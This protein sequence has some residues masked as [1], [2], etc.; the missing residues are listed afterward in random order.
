[1]THRLPCGCLICIICAKK[2][3]NNFIKNKD[4][5]KKNNNLS[6]S[7]CNCGYNLNEKDQE[8]ILNN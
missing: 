8:I 3:I 1:M 2:S 5:N 6:L 4:A 7:I